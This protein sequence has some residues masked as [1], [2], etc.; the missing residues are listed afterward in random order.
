MKILK[1]VFLIMLACVLCLGALTACTGGTPAQSTPGAS[2]PAETDPPAPEYPIITIAEALEKCGES[3]NI[4]TE[5]YYIKGVITTITNPQYGAMVI[6]DET[7]SIPVYGTYSADG[8][9]SYS[10]LDD[11]PYKGDTVILHCILQNYNGTKEVQNARLISFEKSDKVVDE[12]DYADM[13]VAEAREAATG[14]KVKV[15]GVVARITYANGMKPAG[16]YIVDETGSIYVYDADL[17][18]RAKIGNTVT[19]LG[20]KTYWVLDSEKNNADKFG[21]KGCC[22]LEDVTLVNIDNSVKDFDKSWITESTVKDILDTPVSENITAN[23]YKVTALIEKREE[24]GFTNYYIYDLDGTTSSYAYTQC[25]GGDFAWLDEFDGKICT[26]Y[27]S[28]LNAKSTSTDCYFRFI[29]V[30]VI[31]ENFTFDLNDTAEHAVKYYGLTQFNA[32]YTGNPALELVTNVSSTLL[33]FENATLSYSSSNTNVVFF[34]EENGK[35]V[36][37][38]KDAGKATVTV[39]GSYNGKTYEATVEITVAENQKFD[40]ISIADAIGKNVGDEVIL[41]GIVGPS[42]VNKSGFYLFDETGMIAVVVEADVFKN[43][44]IGH[45]IVIKAK[46]DCFKK[47]PASSIAGQTCVTNGVVLA[48]Y[49][50]KH[51]Y[52]IDKFI[53]DEDLKTLYNLSVNEDHSTE[54]Y[55]VKATVTVIEAAYFTNINLVDGDTTFELYCSGAGQYAFLKQ[56][57]GKEVTLEIAPCNWNDKKFYKGCVLAVID[58]NGNKILNELNFLN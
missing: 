4:T 19:I 18:G 31:N 37:N 3:G 10:E 49:Y 6:E 25:N 11:K 57:A 46:R 45:E 26:V 17:A 58:E 48:N 47:D 54:V 28:P 53:L 7:G 35:T 16:V 8:E 41:Q 34:T 2:T 22:Q 14:A 24:P 12:K 40:S 1:H 52:P 32:S 56:F 39:K 30:A 44:K 36:F 27:L 29:P 55:V 5:R 43:I 13:T 50:G 21:Y 23:I 20:S 9:L 33:G 42:L 38:C 15:D 51:D